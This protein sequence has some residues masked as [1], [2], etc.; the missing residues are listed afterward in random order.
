MRSTPSRDIVSSVQSLIKEYRI[1]DVIVDSSTPSTTAIQAASDSFK[2]A[3]STNKAIGHSSILLTATSSSVDN[4]DAQYSADRNH[5]TDLSTL[6]QSS[7]P[8]PDTSSYFLLLSSTANEVIT[9]S[10]A[11]NS[12]LKV[13]SGTRRQS[14]TLDGAAV[15]HSLQSH[16]QKNP[17]PTVTGQPS[18]NTPCFITS[19]VVESRV[20]DMSKAEDNQFTNP[21]SDTSSHSL[22]LPQSTRTE[23]RNRPCQ[24]TDASR[25]TWGD[26]TMEE[27]QSSQKI[28][29][30]GAGVILGCV[31]SASL[32]FVCIFFLHRLFHQSFNNSQKAALDVGNIPKSERS[33]RGRSLLQL[34]HGKEISRFSA[35]T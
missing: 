4:D 24:K 31:C 9:P 28:S 19:A 17:M 2:W 27:A 23:C 5:I 22:L 7:I 13:F 14:S 21:S 33:A 1:S 29:K 11:A 26:A 34:P 12:P 16:L 30:Q 25:P 8:S 10:H 6:Q 35:D 32:L 20:E 15:L 3:G 18:I